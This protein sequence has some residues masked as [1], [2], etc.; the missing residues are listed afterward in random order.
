MVQQ[1]SK[2]QIYVVYDFAAGAVKNAIP[3]V[4]ATQ[5][6]FLTLLADMST[7][8]QAS[9]VLPSENRTQKSVGAFFTASF[10]KE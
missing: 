3:I 2:E 5:G 10:L 9:L 4:S 1:A 7:H 8:V 6:P